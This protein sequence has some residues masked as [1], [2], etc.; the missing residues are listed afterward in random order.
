M[1]AVPKK[2]KLVQNLWMS[3]FPTQHKHTLK[4]QLARVAFSHADSF[5]VIGPG[6]EI[7]ASTSI[8]WMWIEILTVVQPAVTNDI[9]KIQRLFPETVLDNPQSTVH[10]FHRDYFFS[11]K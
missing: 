2:K 8:Q 1:T 4:G 11:R 5:G 10:S 7:F 9:L 3:H 6:F